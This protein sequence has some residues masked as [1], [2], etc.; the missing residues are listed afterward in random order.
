MLTQNALPDEKVRR[1]ADDFQ[2][3][4]DDD[5]DGAIGIAVSGGPDSVAL[6]LLAK[7][8][9]P[10]RIHAATVDHRLRAESSAEARFVSALCAERGIPHETLT[11]DPLPPGNVSANARDARYKALFEWMAR[12][13]LR[14]LA[15]A[16]HADD[17][18]ETLLMRLNRGAAVGGLASIRSRDGAIVR[19]LLGW[20]RRDLVELVA[21]QGIVAVDDPSN[22]DEKYD[23]AR[24]RKAM[25]DAD[26]IDPIALAH[27]AT[28]LDDADTALAW[29]ASEQAKLRV[30]STDGVV[31]FDP[32]GL[33]PEIAR[34]IVAACLRT[35]NP[36]AQ[37]PGPKVTRLL[38]SL[39]RGEKATLDGV[40]CDARRTPWT[41]AP[42]PPRRATK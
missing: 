11:L 35:I 27:S 36:Q 5:R 18:A 33:P 30:S 26:W 24:L 10:A 34:R 14:W 38:L 37:C 19:P 22:R 28:A 29:S 12:E 2:R 17:Q 32:R 39:T 20:R 9:F 3:L 23:R 42:E 25:A 15:T 31:T 4:T 8:A 41:F 16:H 1:F 7:A 40:V 6:L 13:N 21:D